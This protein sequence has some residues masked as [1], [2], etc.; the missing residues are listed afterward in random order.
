MYFPI[1]LIYFL[2]F[3]LKYYIFKKK[4]ALKCSYF[5]LWHELCVPFCFTKYIVN[6]SRSVVKMIPC[7][8][9][10]IWDTTLITDTGKST[11]N[12]ESIIKTYHSVQLICWAC[13]CNIRFQQWTLW[14]SHRCSGKES[15]CQCRRLRRHGLIPGLGRSLE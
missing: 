9:P 12:P 8:P 6:Y 10:L 11:T 4:K 15:T 7:F 14:S 3:F 13:A 5:I 1:F 2:K